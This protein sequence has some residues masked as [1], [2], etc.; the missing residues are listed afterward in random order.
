VLNIKILFYFTI[1]IFFLFFRF[2]IFRMLR[3]TLL[4]LIVGVIA[5]LKADDKAHS[6]SAGA[7]NPNHVKVHFMD[8]KR[9]EVGF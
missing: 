4:F 5:S 6:E 2:E 7:V 3:T 9:E 8:Y 1:Y